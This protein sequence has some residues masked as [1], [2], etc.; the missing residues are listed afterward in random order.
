M[1][2]LEQPV[3]VEPALMAGR[4]P[5]DGPGRQWTRRLGAAALVGG[6]GVIAGVWTPRGPVTVT[7]SLVVMALALLAGGGAGWLLRS[8]LWVLVFPLLYAVAFELTRLPAQGPTVDMLNF[9]EVYGLLAA[10]SG[11]GVHGLMVF[12]ALV[13]G[14]LVGGAIARSR[15]CGPL[16]G[17]RRVLELASIGL[18]V[19]A[20]V[21]LAGTV[22]FPARTEPILGADGRVV[23]GSVAELTRVSVPGGELNVLIRGVSDTNPILLYLAG[24]PGGSEFGAMRRNG[25]ELEQDFVVATLDQRGAGSSYDQLEPLATDTLANAVSDVIE[26]SDHLRTRFGQQEVYLVGQSWGSIIGVL[27]AQQRPDLFAAFVGVGQMVDVTETDQI[28]YDDTLA[29]ARQRGDAKLVARLEAAGTPPYSNLL[30]YPLVLSHEQQ[31]YGYDHSGNAEGAGQMLENL[32]VSEYSPLD[33]VNIVRGLL[34]TFS[35]LYPQLQDLDL[36]RSAA[37][38]EVPVYLVEGRF[39]PRGRKDLARDWFQGLKAPSK[40]WLEFDTSGHRPL[41][42]Q[43]AEFAELMRTVAHQP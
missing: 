43:P 3:I 36:R 5:T 11:R 19:L 2:L 14:G 23:A 21:A 34:D 12:P 26:V 22:V 7:E 24:G 40:Q 8:R 41:F 27:A 30:N 16:T 15:R 1:N 39:E 38:L 32:P 25:A 37:Q 4:Q 17:G 20:L 35:V 9:G 29:W 6:A 28:F 33:M 42:E 31:V 13:A 18:G 10:V